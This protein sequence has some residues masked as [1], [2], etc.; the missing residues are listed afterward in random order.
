MGG[1]RARRELGA[2]SLAFVTISA[3]LAALAAL[4]ARAQ[5]SPPSIAHA[6]S[7]AADE[8]AIRA[9]IDG[10]EVETAAVRIAP[11]FDWDNAFGVRYHDLTKL[12]A[13]RRGTVAP[14]QTSSHRTFLELRV[15]FV[16][17]DVAVADEYSQRI[18]QLDVDTKQR[19]PDR[20]ERTT[21]IFQRVNG[22][23]METIKRIADLRAAY[24]H[25]YATL[26]TPARLSSSELAAF[27][28]AYQFGSRTLNLR[29]DT[30]RFIVTTNSQSLPGPL[31]GIPI[32]VSTLLIFDPND[33]A[34]YR[35]L[36][37]TGASATLSLS[38]DVTPQEGVK[39]P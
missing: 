2:R 37:R 33:L 5:T 11:D 29:R 9:F 14:L 15:Q 28:G 36:E 20:W 31:V 25:H 26:P 38:G 39:L 13:F 17:N 19:G 27:A 10:G 23:W 4:P 3:V 35:I 7:H 30:D 22:T 24:Y 6:P 8:A 34:E 18:G 12:N 1:L 21:F 16:G 32:S